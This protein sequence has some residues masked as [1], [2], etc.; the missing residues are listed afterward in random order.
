MEK[1]GEIKHVPNILKVTAEQRDGFF[2]ERNI[3]ILCVKGLRTLFVKDDITGQISQ[4][5]QFV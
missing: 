1:T 4:Q 3:R 5:R 2:S